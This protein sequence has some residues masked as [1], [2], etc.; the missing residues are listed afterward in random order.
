M[1]KK[2]MFLIPL[3]ALALASCKKEDDPAPT[4]PATLSD[5]IAMRLDSITLAGFPEMNDQGSYWDGGDGS[6]LPDPFVKVYKDNI[7]LFT[8]ATQASASPS[9]VHDM[10]SG[11]TGSLP[12]SF[13]ENAPLK[14]NLYDGDGD[15]SVNAP[16][17][18]GSLE[19]ADPLGFFYGGDHAAGFS[20]LEVTGSNGVTFRLTGTFIY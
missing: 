17:F 7:L 9:G 2:S 5:P 16:D 4:T 10:S 11:G 1:M 19:I 18:I 8:S 6:N 15:P 13:G 3:F 12:I 20:E 14:I